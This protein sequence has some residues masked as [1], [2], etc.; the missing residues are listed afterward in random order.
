MITLKKLVAFVIFSV[1]AIPR[2]AESSY[3]SR[4]NNPYRKSAFLKSIAHHVNNNPDA[5]WHSSL[6]LAGRPPR[7]TK[8]LRPG[9]STTS[10]DWR[11]QDYLREP[12]HQGVTCS[13]C[14]AFASIHAF[15]DYRSVKANARQTP[16]SIH[17]M[18]SCC[19]FSGCV[20]CGGGDPHVG[21]LY[22]NTKGIVEES[23]RPYKEEKLLDKSHCHY[24][25]CKDEKAVPA[26]HHLS[27]YSY[28]EA[29]EEKM[30]EA[31]KTGPIVAGM[32]TYQDFKTY[33]SGIYHYVTGKRGLR[34]MVEIVGYGSESGVNYW[35]CKNSWGT[36]WGERGYFR[37]RA[38]VKESGMEEQG[39]VL[40]P[41]L[42]EGNTTTNTPLL[43]GVASSVDVDDEDIIEAATFAAHELNPFCP[44]ADTDRSVLHNLT[45]IQV[46]RA[47]ATTTAGTKLDITATYQEPG[48]PVTTTYEMTITLDLNGDY[49]LHNYKYI[50][51]HNLQPNSAPSS[52]ERTPQKRAVLVGMLLTALLLT[53]RFI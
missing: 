42:S 25:T 17:N 31:L 27:S 35:I 11:N 18:V 12:E 13:S 52:A 44:G 45:L 46:N 21:F 43:V 22:L 4:T 10:V 39:D 24:N 16:T 5:L 37:I 34:H 32:T 3:D 9:R 8:L 50:P 28:V 29:T 26:T 20:G 41:F 40:S 19:Q 7:N 36:G 15:D 23:C 2:E 38:G 14:W 51:P 49:V 33:K 6:S 48:C 47:A 53:Q 30:R 1:A